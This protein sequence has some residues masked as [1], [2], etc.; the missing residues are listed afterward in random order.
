VNSLQ[1]HY[2]DVSDRLG[3]LKDLVSNAE[4]LRYFEES[5]AANELEVALHALCDFLLERSSLPVSSAVLE[6]V[7]DLHDLMQ[8]E[9]NC[10]EKLKQ[11]G[12]PGQ[13]V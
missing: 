4:G 11:K 8:L 12:R 6:Q 13:Q 7:K 1:G 10:V 5:L 9:D 2:R 3:R